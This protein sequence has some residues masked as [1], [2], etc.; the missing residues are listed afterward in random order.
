MFEL[1]QGVLELQDK[2]FTFVLF[3]IA[4]ML[5]LPIKPVESFYHLAQLSPNSFD[6]FV[7]L[8]QLITQVL[9]FLRKQ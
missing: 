3:V 7:V 2:F 5:E 6:L 8:P 4:P 1:E 9:D